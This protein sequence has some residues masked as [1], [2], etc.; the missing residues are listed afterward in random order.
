MNDESLQNSIAYCIVVHCEYRLCLSFPGEVSNP[1]T[2]WQH[3][4]LFLKKSYDG[5]SRG[6]TVCD[7]IQER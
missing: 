2:F 1:S 6:A 7:V 4:I 3:V 5:K